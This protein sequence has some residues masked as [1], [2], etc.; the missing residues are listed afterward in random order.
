M[1]CGLCGGCVLERKVAW[2]LGERKRGSESAFQNYKRKRLIRVGKKTEE[3]PLGGIHMTGMRI[4]EKGKGRKST[5]SNVVQ[6]MIITSQKVRPL[7]DYEEVPNVL[8]HCSFH[9][10]FGGHGKRSRFMRPTMYGIGYDAFEEW[11]L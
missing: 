5:G 6:A 8:F 10:F 11:G 9:P 4:R 7:Y 2:D 3:M 1:L